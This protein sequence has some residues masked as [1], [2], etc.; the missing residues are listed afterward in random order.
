LDREYTEFR[1]DQTTPVREFGSYRAPFLA[2][3]VS[4]VAEGQ[5]LELASFSHRKTSMTRFDQRLYLRPAVSFF[6]A[7]RQPI[8][9][10]ESPELCWG[11]KDGAGAAWTRIDIPP[12]T[13][14]VLVNPSIERPSQAIDTRRYLGDAPS[15]GA[16]AVP[17]ALISEIADARKSYHADLYVGLYG[18]LGIEVVTPGKVPLGR[19]RV[20]GE[21]SSG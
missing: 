16:G 20:A 4:D 1:I 11:E 7:Q 2:L 14:F 19:C 3:A 8:E 13:R 10:V 9:R 17:D 5:Q 15:T 18:L 12:G 21:V 6:D